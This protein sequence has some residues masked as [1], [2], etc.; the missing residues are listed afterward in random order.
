M[1]T[2]YNEWNKKN[3]REGGSSSRMSDYEQ[4][5]NSKPNKGFLEG[6]RIV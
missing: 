2:R 6:R 5:K 4:K 1:V 3:Y